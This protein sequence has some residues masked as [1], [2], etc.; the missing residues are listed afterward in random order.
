MWSTFKMT[1]KSLVR[2]PAILI[3]CVVFPLAL[4]SLF[5]IMFSNLSSDGTLDPISVAVVEDENWNDSN[6]SEVVDT[7]NEEG[8]DRLLS[9]TS[10]K[11]AKEGRA[12]IDEQRVSGMYAVN[13]KGKPVV[14]LAPDNY[15]GTPE[16]SSLYGTILQRIADG[17]EQN[18]ALVKNAIE[19]NPFR[20]VVRQSLTDALDI[21]VEAEKFSATRAVPDETVRYYYV[22][23]AMV[24]LLA[25][26]Q[27]AS[28]AVS[29]LQPNISELGARR[30]VSGTGHA[31]QLLGVLLGC[32]LVSAVCTA[33]TFAFIR[34]VVGIDFAGREGLCLVGLA[35]S[36][37]CSTALGALVSALPL[38]G[39]ADVRSGLLIAITMGLCVFAGLFGQF[40]MSLADNIAQA[41]PAEAW[42]NPPRLISDMFYSLYY[43]DSIEPFALRT[44]GCAG[45]AAAMFAC[46]AIFF[47][48]QRY[49]HL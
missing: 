6:F 3:W 22:L 20:L 17:Y 43:Y 7:L 32:W 21:T 4:T 27:A 41:C 15:A 19:D 49:E 18:Y 45:L 12:L 36:T 37:L 9:V 5:M 44:L 16:K 26:S 24:A 34:F 13:D 10:V 2:T 33:I 46:S 35:A 38:K 30:F 1:L 23:L 14:T 42:L 11:T 28:L 29:E 40:S 25:G 48:R 47:R 39:G 31:R 8:D